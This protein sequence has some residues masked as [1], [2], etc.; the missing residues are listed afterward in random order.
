MEIVEFELFP[1]ATMQVVFPGD[2]GGA[3]IGDMRDAF[4]DSLGSMLG[5]D[6]S[7]IV[8]HLQGGSIIATFYI[9]APAANAPADEP[10]TVQAYKRLQVQFADPVAREGFGGS[11]ILGGAPIAFEPG[12]LAANPCNDIPGL[13]MS[14]GVHNCSA[15][16][17]A[18]G[19]SCSLVCDAGTRPSGDGVMTCFMGAF[20]LETCVAEECDILPGGSQF[21][22]PGATHDCKDLFDNMLRHEDVCQITCDPSPRGT[23]ML[24]SAG[25]NISCY[26]GVLSE[27]ISRW[28]RLAWWL[29]P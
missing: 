12:S 14:N 11:T 18:S 5:V 21:Q 8:V 24:P 6:S 3:Y 1:V 28:T 10:S 26:S 2:W 17:M 25:G 13:N 9:K 22:I 27:R 16:S 29:R 20:E 23:P 7:R 15:S 4:A 19:S